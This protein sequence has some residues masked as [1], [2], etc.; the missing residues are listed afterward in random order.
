MK[1]AYTHPNIALVVQAQDLFEHAGIKCVIRNQYAS[2]AIGELAPV[3]AWPEVW[4]L[5]DRDYDR[6]AAILEAQQQPLDE[7]DW[8][9]TKCHNANPASFETCWHCGSARC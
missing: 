4:V 6:A 7:P 9:C 1:L 5:E 3:S 2:G 8:Y